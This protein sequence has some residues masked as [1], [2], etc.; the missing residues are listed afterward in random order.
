[1]K[2]ENVNRKSGILNVLVNHEK[3]INNFL[4]DLV[5]SNDLLNDPCQKVKAILSRPSIVYGHC[6]V[7]EPIDHFVPPIRSILSTIGNAT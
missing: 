2:F 7:H 1:M 5:S 6:K 4:K 3:H